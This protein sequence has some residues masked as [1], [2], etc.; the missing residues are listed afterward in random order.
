MNK[1]VLTYPLTD[2]QTVFDYVWCHFIIEKNPAGL[3]GHNKV[4]YNSPTC[5]CSIGCLLPENVRRVMGIENYSITMGIMYNFNNLQSIFCTKKL[6]GN[7]LRLLQD[8]QTA[9]DVSV[10]DAFHLKFKAAMMELAIKYSL[11]T[12][13]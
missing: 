12:H 11:K 2:A 7:F 4:S 10:G 3:D 5:G 13:D 8:L 1:P 9:H 6:D